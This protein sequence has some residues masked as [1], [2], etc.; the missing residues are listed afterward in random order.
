MSEAWR[1]FVAAPLGAELAARL[2]EAVDQWRDRPDLAGL[3]WG[4]PA[5]WHLT[6]VFLGD[7]DP[8]TIDA[9]TDRLA[10]AAARHEPTRVATGGL[11]GFPSSTRARVAWY[12]VGDPE[13]R[14]RALADD[15]GRA[16]DL[17]PDRPFNAHVTLGRA[18]GPALDLRTW[19]RDAAPP[20]GHLDVDRLELVRSRPGGDPVHYEAL[21]SVSLG[22]RR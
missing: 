21:A 10:A 2:S 13:A 7:V 12:G 16:V 20:V 5:N 6:F 18:R 9:L 1:C 15:V 19:V 22:G 17:D 4:D 11:G 8:G 14:L 3:R